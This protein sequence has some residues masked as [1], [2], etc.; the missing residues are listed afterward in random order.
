MTATT[1]PARH[2]CLPARVSAELTWRLAQHTSRLDWDAADLAAHQR[3][4]L[5]VLLAYAA[6]YSPFHARRL[7]GLD[8]SRFEPGDLA[9]LPVMTKSQM[10][11]EFDD[12]VT[13]RRLSRRLAEQHMAASAHAPGLLLDEYVCLASG[14][15]SGLRGVFVQTLG[16]YT[17]FVASLMRRGY[18]RALAAG[19]P[20]QDGLVIGLVAAASPVHSSG[21][22]A[23]VA[24]GPPVRLVAA[25]ATLPLDQIVARLNAAQPPALLGYASKLAEL[26]CEQLAGRL[27][28]APRSVISNAEVLTAADRAVIERAFAVPVIDSF[29][30]TEG[31]VGHSEPGGS[32]MSFASDMCLAEPVDDDNNPAPPGAPSAK[33][34]V[35]NL[36]NLTQPLV[37]Y[38]L[39]DRFTTPE[40]TPSAGWLRASVEGRADEVFR[41][42]GVAVHPHVIRSAL[43]SA[44]A[45][46]EY[47]VRQTE[48]GIDVTCVTGGHFA[49]TALA[50]RLEHA[51]RQAGLTE[52]HVSIRLAETIT[53]N[54]NTG[55]VSRFIPR[56]AHLAP[57]RQAGP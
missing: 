2:A 24:A 33:V 38:E 19:G 26:A 9:G 1:V 41:Y 10:M 28:I 39:T 49:T 22:G 36:H 44:G 17:D 29:V 18:A 40:G 4:R 52:P 21:F 15:S 34:L 55:K 45:V 42:G 14:G 51:L 50:A 46:R 27:A 6:E 20:P 13:D 35:T 56:R 3:Q 11:A 8:L 32:V 23:A 5:R 47:Q 31:L 12:V 7:R 57:P 54:P 43:A 53:R 37:R 25:P 16:Q 30:S 48:D